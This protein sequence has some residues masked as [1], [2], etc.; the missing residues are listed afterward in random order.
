MILDFQYFLCALKEP[1]SFYAYRADD[2]S[3]SVD[4]DEL[5]PEEKYEIAV[6]WGTMTGTW[7]LM[8]VI[9]GA[10]VSLLL[11]YFLFFPLKGGRGLK[12]VEQDLA[13][14]GFPSYTREGSSCEPS[15]WM[16]GLVL[17]L[18]YVITCNKSITYHLFTVC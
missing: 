5:Q 6:S 8:V 14:D 18:W 4:N 2:M 12:G 1:Q 9:C 10:R 16:I 15:A 3:S 7:A 13:D 17:L 11:F